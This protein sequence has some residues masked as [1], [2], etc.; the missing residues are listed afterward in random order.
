[1]DWQLFGL[2][3]ITVFLAEI[4]DKSQLAAIALGGS[5]KSPRAVFFGS[6]TALILA[7][8][9][10]VLAGGSLAQFLPTK[11]LKALAALGFTI[12]ALRLLWPNQED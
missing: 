10:G 6:V 9:L 3:F 5:A 8:F 7:S 12:M 1:M 2:S 11:L 4:G